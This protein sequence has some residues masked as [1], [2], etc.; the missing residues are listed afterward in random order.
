MIGGVYLREAFILVTWI[1]LAK[2]ILY[3]LNKRSVHLLFKEHYPSAELEI[4][5]ITDKLPLLIKL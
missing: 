1:N 4:E 5:Y 3:D 2:L